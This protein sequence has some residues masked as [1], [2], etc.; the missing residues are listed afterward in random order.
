[1]SFRFILSNTARL[2]PTSYGDMRIQ[3]S[4]KAWRMPAMI[5]QANLDNLSKPVHMHGRTPS[6][7]ASTTNN[8]TAE[9]A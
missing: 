6:L 5:A 2:A 7:V 9:D 8:E 4:A 3:G 1:M